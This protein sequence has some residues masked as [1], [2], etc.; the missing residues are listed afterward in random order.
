[1]GRAS[2]LVERA[3]PLVEM[4]DQ[5]HRHIAQDRLSEL[6]QEPCGTIPEIRRRMRRNAIQETLS[7][8]VKKLKHIRRV[9]AWVTVRYKCVNR[10]GD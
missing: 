10:A 8:H 1:M 2:F 3:Q 4:A 5:E 7:N 9:E 6:N